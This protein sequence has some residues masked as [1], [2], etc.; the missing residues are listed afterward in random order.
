[1]QIKNGDIILNI[2]AP[3]IIVKD[4]NYLNFRKKKLIV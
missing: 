1:M 4:R 3:V 2:S